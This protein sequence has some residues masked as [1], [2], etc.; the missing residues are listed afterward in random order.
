MIETLSIFMNTVFKI[1]QDENT[2]LEEKFELIAGKY[3][4]RM[5]RNPDMPYFVLN[6][7]RT[8][9]EEFFMQITKGRKFQ[10]FVIYHQL[11][12]RLG[13]ERASQISAYHIMTNLMSLTIFPFVGKPMMKMMTDIDEKAF[14]AMMEERKKLIPK[15]VLSMLE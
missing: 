7:L 10:D 5:K 2:S 3:I 13:E 15:W 12:E 9:P 11:V 14:K 8:K 1:F 6:E 4:D